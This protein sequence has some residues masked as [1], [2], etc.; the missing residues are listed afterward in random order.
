MS[1]GKN[2]LAASV[3]FASRPTNQLTGHGTAALT[4]EQSYVR[5]RVE[6]AYACGIH[7]MH[8]VRILHPSHSQLVWSLHVLQQDES[9]M[10]YLPRGRSQIADEIEKGQAGCARRSLKDSGLAGLARARAAGQYLGERA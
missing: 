7:A 8:D 2:A 6:E 3:D 10:G 4:S 5:Q 9:S 1:K